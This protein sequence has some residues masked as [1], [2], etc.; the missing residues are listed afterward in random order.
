MAIGKGIKTHE[1][2]T[3]EY[4]NG[5]WQ[6]N[7]EKVIQEFELLSKANQITNPAEEEPDEDEEADKDKEETE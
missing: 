6:D 1:Q 7:A 5:D 3:R 4:G 2:V